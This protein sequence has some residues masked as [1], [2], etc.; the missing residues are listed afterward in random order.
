MF[1]GNWQKPAIAIL[2]FGTGLGLNLN[3]VNG[4]GIITRILATPQTSPPK[5]NQQSFQLKLGQAIKLNSISLRFL[6]I[7]EDSRCPVGAQCIWAGDAT[8]QLDIQGPG[9][10]QKQVNLSL[11]QP[12]Q[13]NSFGLKY[14]IKLVQLSPHPGSQ[15]SQAPVATLT[16]EKL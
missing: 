1:G 10:L 13:L 7:L 15:S 2:I 8:I 11:S 12:G 4:L 3:P 16:V 5:D 6:Q 14:Q 9:Q